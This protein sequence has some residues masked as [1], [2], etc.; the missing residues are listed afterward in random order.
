MI[1]ASDEQEWIDRIER[2]RS[3][4]ETQADARR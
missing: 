4:G 3:I 2:R 1:W